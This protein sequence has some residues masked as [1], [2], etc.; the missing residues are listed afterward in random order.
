MKLAKLDYRTIESHLGGA[1]AFVG[2]KFIARGSEDRTG[3]LYDFG[4]H[5][6]NKLNNR[7]ESFIL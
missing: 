4:T 5:Y 2:L 7:N 1:G 3:R 6:A